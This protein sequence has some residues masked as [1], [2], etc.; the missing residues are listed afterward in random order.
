[1]KIADFCGRIGQN[2]VMSRTQGA[3]PLTK[4]AQPQIGPMAKN[5]T[6]FRFLVKAHDERYR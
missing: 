5:G 3:L 4:R 1:V 6:A 2:A